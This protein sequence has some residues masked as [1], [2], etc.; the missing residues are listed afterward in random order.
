[1]CFRFQGNFNVCIKP[2]IGEL[3]R[4]ITMPAKLFTEKQSTLRGMNEFTSNVNERKENIVEKILTDSNLGLCEILEDT[5]RF[6]LVVFQWIFFVMMCI[7]S[8]FAGQ[9]YTSSSLILVTINCFNNE[10]NVV[11]N[12][13]NIVFGDVLLNHLLNTL[14]S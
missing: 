2:I 4:P 6:E 1:M 11:L 7:F 8:R 13:E 14:K 10:T 3:I 12:C 5:Y 9:T